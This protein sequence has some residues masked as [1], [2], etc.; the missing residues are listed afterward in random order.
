M[1]VLAAAILLEKTWKHGRAFSRVTGASLI[2]FASFVPA[3]PWLLPGLY[4]NP[5]M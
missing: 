2:V 3:Y 4:M 1:A 5:A